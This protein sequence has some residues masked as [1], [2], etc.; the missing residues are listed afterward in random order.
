MKKRERK[1]LERYVRM[2]AGEVG[3]RDWA[4]YF[5]WDKPADE[6]DG[7]SV[8]WPEGQKRARLRFNERFREY[9]PE[10]QRRFVVHELVHCHFAPM[11]DTVEEDLQPHLSRPTYDIYSR[12]FRRDLEYGIDAVA[13][14]LA[15]HMPLIDWSAT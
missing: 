6:G 11:Q 14:T 3:L 12:G 15:R 7:A 8:W 10:S 5:D 13:D 2:V 1:A 4:F 9:D